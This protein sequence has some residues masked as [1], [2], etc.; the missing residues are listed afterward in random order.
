MHVPIQTY[1][2]S[3]ALVFCTVLCSSFVIFAHFHESS[4][5]ADPKPIS[6]STGGSSNNDFTSGPNDKDKDKKKKKISSVD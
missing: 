1:E 2:T 5:K 4:S 3:I 6:V